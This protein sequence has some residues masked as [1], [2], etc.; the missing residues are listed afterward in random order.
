MGEDWATI[1]RMV[2]SNRAN[3]LSEGMTWYLGACTS[4][5]NSSDVSDAP[6][7]KAKRRAFCLKQSY[8]NYKLGFTGKVSGPKVI[9][10]PPRGKSIERFVLDEMNSYADRY[11]RDIA[12][13]LGRTD[14]YQVMPKSHNALLAKLLLKA[15]LADKVERTAGLETHFEQF[16]KAG[17]ITKAV[18]LESDGRLV[19]SISFP[20]FKWIDLGAE[21]S[22]EDSEL[23]GQLTSKFLFLVFKKQQDSEERKFDGA[24][25]WTMPSSDLE[26][27]K[28]LWGDTVEKIRG[29][30][31]SSFLKKTEHKIGHVRPHARDKSDT[32]PT[33]QGG[34]ET[35][36]SFWLNNSYVRELIRLNAS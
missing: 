12:K 28:K 30:D 4:G 16:E 24:F 19:E 10:T 33:P 23:Y 9:L 14:I 31:Y 29:G 3:E 7:G 36:K 18:C 35:K 13:E 5:A 1:K 34:A 21:E 32:F 2:T 15:I 25:F 20:A 11:A 6:G 27:M 26:V 17:V 8:L 22:W